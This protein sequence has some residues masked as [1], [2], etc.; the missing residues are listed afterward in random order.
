MSSYS[1]LK[2]S[3]PPELFKSLLEKN[4][5]SVSNMPKPEILVVNDPADARIRFDMSTGDIITIIT[6]GPETVKYRGNVQY[7]DRVYPLTLE[8]WTK[9]DRQRL[10]DI[11][12]QIKGIVFDHL[13]AIEGYQIIRL[14]SYTEMV[15]D[16][17]NIWKGQVKLTV[18]AA[19]VCVE[20]NGDYDRFNA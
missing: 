7:Y 10:R 12:K 16:A 4:W 13:F 19:G 1:Y 9:V 11:W 2:E 15:N 5:I 20:T 14:Q 8:I 6:S 18:E 3:L 17:V